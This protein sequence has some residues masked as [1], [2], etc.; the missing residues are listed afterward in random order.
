MA[1]GIEL[2]QITQQFG[3]LLVAVCRVRLHA[4]TDDRVNGRGNIGVDFTDGR[5]GRVI[6]SKSSFMAV[7]PP[8][9]RVR[10]TSVS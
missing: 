5:G 1:V 10:P 8:A 6:R 4:P 7:W 2:F 3:R 9:N